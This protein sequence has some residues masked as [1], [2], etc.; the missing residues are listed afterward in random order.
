M[1]SI[2][3]PRR[4]FL[5]RI[6][7]P[8]TMLARRCRLGAVTLLLCVVLSLSSAALAAV[9]DGEVERPAGDPFGYQMRGN[10][11][12]G[13]Y[14]QKVN[15]GRLFVVSFTQAFPPFD[16]RETRTLRLHWRKPSPK[17]VQLRAQSLRYRLY[18]RMDAVVDTD[19]AFAW[20]TDVFKAVGM[21]RQDLGVMAWTH[22]VVGGAQRR[23]Y[24]PLRILPVKQRS[25]E[26]AGPYALTVRAGGE[27]KEVYLSVASL[28]RDGRKQFIIDGE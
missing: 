9:C 19:T 20:P 10:R 15:S 14:V 5:G 7:V 6:H 1:R 24:L 27:V 18:Y 3:P 22:M 2:D 23:V 17:P 26:S 4:R 13:R 8:R 21:G 11:C 28:D 12:E 16:A 25:P